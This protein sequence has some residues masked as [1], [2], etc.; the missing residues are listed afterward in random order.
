[1]QSEIRKSF[2]NSRNLASER[3][4]EKVYVSRKDDA[5][6]LSAQKKSTQSKPINQFSPGLA[7]NKSELLKATPKTTINKAFVNNEASH[8]INRQINSQ[9]FSW[10]NNIYVGSR[11]DGLESAFQN[12]IIEHE[13]I[14]IEQNKKNDN[15]AVIQ[16]ADDEGWTLGGLVNSGA[17]YLMDAAKEKFISPLRENEDYK[18]MTGV[19]GKDL[20]TGEAV[21]FEPKKF[22][23]AAFKKVDQQEYYQALDESGVF[24]KFFTW[25]TNR[26]KEM[27]LSWSYFQ[28]IIQRV[29]NLDFI[30][31]GVRGSISEF[32]KI[33]SEPITKIVTFLRDVGKK[34][35]ELI[36]DSFLLSPAGQWLKKFVMK[37]TT[38]FRAIF[39]TPV[40]FFKN[41]F[42]SL[43][44]GFQQFLRNI[45]T[46]L[47]EGV[48][49][50]LLGSLTE[51]GVELNRPLSVTSV[52][53]FALGVIGVSY[54]NFRK[55]LVKEIAKKEADKDG[56]DE[57][58]ERKMQL[59]E[60]SF[61][62]VQAYRD[63]GIIGVWEFLKDK[64]MDAF[65][66]LKDAIIEEI[67]NFL[68]VKI[69]TIAVEKVIA[70]LIPAAAILSAI[71][72]GVEVLFV[73]IDQIRNALKIIEGIFDAIIEIASGALGR[74]ANFV[75]RTLAK[76]IPICIAF[77]A[78]L[79]GLG[80]IPRKIRD[81]L[82][83]VKKHV[84]KALG[85][86]AKMF[87]KLAGPV[88]EAMAR[89]AEAVDGAIEGI[90]GFV[91]SLFHKEE[92]SIGDH[93]HTFELVQNE[94]SAHLIM[95]SNPIIFSN[96]MDEI[97]LSVDSDQALSAKKDE[98]IPILDGLKIKAKAIEDDF[99]L[100]SSQANNN[101]QEVG[102]LKT[103]VSRS[104]T[105]LIISLKQNA[106]QHNFEHLLNGE[107]GNALS[108]MSV[109][110]EESYL[111]FTRKIKEIVEKFEQLDSPARS[112]RSL[113]TFKTSAIE[114]ENLTLEQWQGKSSE[115]KTLVNLV[116]SKIG[117][118]KS[119]MDK[120]LIELA[121][122][123]L[124]ND[125]LKNLK[126]DT[127]TQDAVKGI[128]TD[129]Y[130]DT[131]KDIEGELGRYAVR[132]SQN[133]NHNGRYDSLKVEADHSPQ[134]S[135]LE[136]I[137]KFHVVHKNVDNS[138]V[139]DK[140]QVFAGKSSN[141]LKDTGWTMNLARHRHALTR[142]YLNGAKKTMDN[143]IKSIKGELNTKFG[144]PEILQDIGAE[145]N[146]FVLKYSVSRKM[147]ADVDAFQKIIF[148]RLTVERQDDQNHIQNQ[149]LP[150]RWAISSDHKS[151]LRSRS[152]ELKSKTDFFP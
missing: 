12:E 69:V 110:D 88:L 81:I 39:E 60:E 143:F 11:F 129:I 59:L 15:S 97:K 25:F 33:M 8:R 106:R 151:K 1:M 109:V 7:V 58:A 125:E 29:L 41:V 45:L 24:P 94:G 112:G 16:R 136:K 79:L 27:N 93:N 117:K 103:L 76:A 49:D 133:S 6:E 54:E 115:P 22:V 138:E 18:L 9:A 131:L 84:D 68:I 26:F 66:D 139:K 47:L 118:A 73:M 98:I 61:E 71:K 77:L 91:G 95:K 13:K 50:W 127:I 53:M 62:L 37:A 140:S 128:N 4:K 10:N 30:S 74:A 144:Q 126:K 150:L 102:K 75:E 116:E 146:E 43:K 32:W 149:I 124:S 86:L 67:R 5:N 101:T 80:G 130:E 19:V 65:A 120:L 82:L 147:S 132:A 100:K 21:A 123:G 48:I 46:H 152:E 72:T 44:L 114:I 90:K 83:K 105:D 85:V 57:R 2:S 113:A 99:I 87:L 51:D 20:F 92:F 104:I 35:A 23:E 108:E 111:C 134:G 55:I 142:T 56:A 63:R 42:S 137:A 38:V 145:Q 89:A 3:S 40:Q 28:G 36:L 34:V 17:S 70:L 148:N 64:I 107:V 141:G 96:L 31:L 122:L 78:G 119:Q 135:I 14:H 121:K 52:V